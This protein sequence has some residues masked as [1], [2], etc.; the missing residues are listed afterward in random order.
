[1]SLELCFLPS[2]STTTTTTFTMSNNSTVAS[3][4][5][6]TPRPIVLP[7]SPTSSSLIYIA[8]DGKEIDDALLD[9]CAKLFSNNYGIWGQSPTATQGPKPGSL[10]P[11]FAFP[12]RLTRMQAVGLGC[13]AAGFASN[14]NQLELVGHAFATAWDYDGGRVG[15]VT[16]LVVSVTARKRYIATSLLQMLKLRPI[17]RGI[18]A[19][20]LVSSHP[21][22]CHALSNYTNFSIH[23]VD[24]SFCQQN[25]KSILE[26]SPVDYVSTM[27]L[28]G[29]LFE[30]NST[31]G[32]ISSA[33]TNF[34]VDH[35]EPLEALAAYRAR[36]KWLLGELLDGHEFLIILPAQGSVL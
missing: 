3:T 4:Q 31:S 25:A 1:M 15:W 35:Q 16:Q 9:R 18:T 21:S 20:G 12:M 13:L 23:S 14:P 27:E 32:A 34:Y 29:S 26:A 6:V 5:P 8:H 28:R 36:G 10:P 11:S 17:F 2:L 19:I 7:N 22:A 24:M 33:F 30:D